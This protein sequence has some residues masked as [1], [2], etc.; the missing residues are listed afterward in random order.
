M[1]MEEGFEEWSGSHEWDWDPT[2]PP[3]QHQPT[4]PRRCHTTRKPPG[5][6]VKIRR[7]KRM[8][9][10]QPGMNRRKMNRRTLLANEVT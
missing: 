10:P 6:R 1:K 9:T 3:S 5:R 4:P 2:P 7:S 8:S